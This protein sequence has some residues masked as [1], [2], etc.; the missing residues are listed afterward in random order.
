MTLVSYNHL[1]PCLQLLMEDCGIYSRCGQ[2]GRF[3]THQLETGIVYHTPSPHTE[4]KHQPLLWLTTQFEF[5]SHTWLGG[6]FLQF[7]L[8]PLACFHH[9]YQPLKNLGLLAKLYRESEE[10]EI[11]LFHSMTSRRD[12][13][14]NIHVY[15]YRSIYRIDG[16]TVRY[17][18][19]IFT[20]Y[21]LTF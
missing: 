13:G 16:L 8:Q 19:L 10:W 20:T 21:K 9:H 14:L 17:S 2:Q 11:N 15:L 6:D 4:W 18:R 1:H 5:L 3:H 7:L 12:A